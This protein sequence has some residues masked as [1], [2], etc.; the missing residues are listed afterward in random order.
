MNQEAYPS[1]SR[2]ITPAAA[3]AA[4]MPG[5][6]ELANE[7][8][9]GM[10]TA[11]I[12][13]G[14]ALAVADLFGR[15]S[16]AEDQLTVTAARAALGLM[17]VGVDVGTTITDLDA[18]QAKTSAGHLVWLPPVVTGLVDDAEK[19]G[20]VPAWPSIVDGRGK[21]DVDL[22]AR[23]FRA[24]ARTVLTREDLPTPMRFASSGLIHGIFTLGRGFAVAQPVSGYD[25]GVF[26]RRVLGGDG[27]ADKANAGLIT[28]LL[29][30]DCRHHNPGAATVVDLETRRSLSRA[31]EPSVEL[32]VAGG[33]LCE[34]CGNGISL[35]RR[36]DA[37]FCSKQCQM[38]NASRRAH[39]RRRE[40]GAA[41]SR[42]TD[43]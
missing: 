5:E 10:N 35:E 37:R 6:A 32:G 16:R 15:R 34:E 31:E 20:V 30:W 42:G 38:R 39:I 1:N 43:Q 22:A 40:A 8:V 3:V 28:R 11:E 13:L 29:D 36:R 21:Y 14:E 24:A 41:A 33:R 12:T 23:Q 26:W 18:C 2:A 19:A 25:L 7:L 9:A 4:G 27:P 17:A